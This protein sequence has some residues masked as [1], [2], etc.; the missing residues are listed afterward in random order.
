MSLT[1]RGKNCGLVEL[2]L[3]LGC[4]VAL[5]GLLEIFYLDDTLVTDYTQNIYSLQHL[6]ERIAD[7]IATV[8]PDMILWTWAEL[9]YRLDVCHDTGGAHIETY[10]EV[11]KIL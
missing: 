6:M 2:L 10:N 1:Y 9:D 3:L 4:Q 8:T 5:P 7:G 11:N